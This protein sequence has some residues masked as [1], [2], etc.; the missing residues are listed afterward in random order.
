[1]NFN[2]LTAA[3][4]PAPIPAFSPFIG[5]KASELLA[6]VQR[7]IAASFAREPALTE[8]ADELF[9]LADAYQATQP[10]YADDLRAAARNGLKAMQAPKSPSAAL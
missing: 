2:A 9:A 4:R 1:M 3:M 10:S 7:V 6:S 8:A 5:R